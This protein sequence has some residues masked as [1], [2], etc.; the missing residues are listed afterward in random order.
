MTA[1]MSMH[2]M[3]ALIPK[4]NAQE[5]AAWTSVVNTCAM[6]LELAAP[7]VEPTAACASLP[8]GRLSLSLEEPL[9]LPRPP[10]RPTL[11]QDAGAAE[12]EGGGGNTADAGGIAIPGG[13]ASPEPWHPRGVLVRVQIYL[14][15]H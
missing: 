10:S 4:H 3:D 8:A 14:I 13:A 6:P 12:A 11:G 5:H 7:A 9:S 1:I 2:D 15:S